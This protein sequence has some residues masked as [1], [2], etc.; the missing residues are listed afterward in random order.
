MSTRPKYPQP[1]PP[2]AASGICDAD[3]TRTYYPHSTRTGALNAAT[4]AAQRAGQLVPDLELSDEIFRTAPD[5][6]PTLPQEVV[7]RQ[8]REREE[9]PYG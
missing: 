5:G 2:D 9:F 7:H 1:V 8:V 4:Y 6:R 3:G